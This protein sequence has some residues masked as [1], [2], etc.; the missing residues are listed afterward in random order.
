MDDT[1]TPPVPEQIKGI[2]I[3]E[4]MQG[5]Y[6]EYAMSVIAGRALPDVR[7]GL[8]PVHRRILF[9]MH[10][11]GNTYDKRY[12]KSARVVGDVIGKYHPHG[13]SAVYNAMVRMAQDF[14]QRYTLVDGQG[15]FGSIDGDNA[16]AMRYTESRM[17]RLGGALLTD[18]EKNTVDFG[19]NYDGSLEEPKVLPTRVPNLLINGSSGIAVG[20]STNIPPHNINE[21]I[22]GCIA[23]IENPDVTLDDLMKIIPGPDLPTAGIISNVKGI[24]NAYRYGRGTFYI[25]GRAEIET[26]GKD[27]EAIVVTELPYQVNKSTWIES[28]AHHVREK[29]IEGI[30]DLRDESNREGIRVV[31]ELKKGESSNVVL[32]ALYAKTQLQTSFGV[33]LLAIDNGRP[34]LFNLKECLQ[35]FIDHR[36][37]VVT[38]RC[39]YELGKAKDREHIL[40]GLKT[41]LDNIDEVVELIK[42]A[43]NA[44]EAR[45]NLQS[46]FAMSEKQAQAV[47]DMR[48]Q[49][50]TALEVKE[51]VAELEE[52][53][54]AIARLMEILNSNEE[55]FKV[56]RGELEETLKIFGDKRKT[57]IS[58]SEEKDYEVED[59]IR[60]EQVVVTVTQAG[61]VKRSSSEEYTAQARGGKGIRG[62]SI[63]ADNDFVS[64]LFV[65]STL[66]YLLCF[67]NKGRLHWLKVHQIPEMSRT[68][69][70]RP[71]VQFLQLEKEEKVLS[72]LPVSKFE[73]NKYV[74][75]A[76]KKGVVK[77]TDLMAFKNVRTNGIIALSIDEGDSLINAAITEGNDDVF[78]AT[79][80]GQSIRFSEADVRDMG[81]TARG[82]K[83]IEIADNDQVVDMAIIPAKNTDSYSILS[84]SSNGYGKRT[85]IAEYRRQ[86][87]GGSGIINI[88]ANERIGALVGV[89]RVRA[90]DDVLIISNVGQII[91]TSVSDISEIGRN[92]QGVRVIRLS[93]G[94]MVNAI[95]VVQEVEELKSNETVH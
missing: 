95:A 1:S 43:G 55:L 21:I 44:A 16:A 45:T 71:I 59:F 62:A 10:D 92:T 33:I 61:Y 89:K 24:K 34:K 25:K 77:K 32:N 70:G 29:E 12:L 94:E 27:R 23:I 39:V 20:M 51:L 65:A 19:P 8:K 76:T 79:K 75:M 28:I 15:N 68:A 46:R 85:P 81:R 60:D 67:T 3:E 41:A 38:R 50:L 22:Q 2:K 74:V 26:W 63:G 66:S 52:I 18:I 14:S 57:E 73:E 58:Y 88:K 53:K 11:L 87:R 64:D 90:V 17:S 80:E 13:D 49:K 5:A 7:D 36:A 30:S 6:L 83:G 84:V 72:I 42:K 37:D 35:A 54:K 40:L 4:E 48:L 86:G 82:V 31:I 78:I 69:R 56:I 93:E 91:R 47:L 9:A